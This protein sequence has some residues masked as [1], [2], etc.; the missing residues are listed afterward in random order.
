MLPIHWSA[1]ALD[2]LDDIVAYIA[3]FNPD[4]AERLHIRI[5]SVVLPL[6]NNPFLYRASERWHGLREIVAHP[7][8]LVFY[9]VLEDRIEIVS[10]A[11]ARRNFP[12]S[13]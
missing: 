3:Q 4:A 5:E 7:N 12:I 8:Y 2:E 11:H 10:V 6:A 1:R 9:R 13:P